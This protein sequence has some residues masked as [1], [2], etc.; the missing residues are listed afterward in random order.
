YFAHPP[1]IRKLVTNKPTTQF[2]Q[3]QFDVL[4]QRLPCWSCSSPRAPTLLG[5]EC[6]DRSRAVWILRR[7]LYVL[8]SPR[9]RCRSPDTSTDVFTIRAVGQEDFSDVVVVPDA[10]A[11]PKKEQK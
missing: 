4:R 10:P 5:K 2:A 7:C 11:V 1:C 9:S 8:Y 3:L 6:A